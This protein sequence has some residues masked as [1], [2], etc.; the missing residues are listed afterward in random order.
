MSELITTN[1]PVLEEHPKLKEALER[2]ERNLKDGD[3]KNIGN[4][5]RAVL[6]YIFRQYS[7]DDPFVED[8]SLFTMV[9]S[10]GARGYFSPE[11]ISIIEQIRKRGN[12]GS[13]AD[14]PFNRVNP[15]TVE[16][17]RID[18][19]TLVNSF[20][21]QFLENFPKPVERKN[22]V[23]PIFHAKENLKP[24]RNL[25]VS[26]GSYYQSSSLRTDL[27]L[28]DDTHILNLRNA[29]KWYEEE[30]IVFQNGKS[31]NVR[32]GRF[33]IPEE[34]R[35]IFGFS[36][37]SKEKY[38]D[39][40]HKTAYRLVGEYSFSVI[41]TLRAL[42]QYTGNTHTVYAPGV[43]LEQLENAAESSAEEPG[44]RDLINDVEVEALSD[45]HLLILPDDDSFDLA[46][47]G[48]DSWLIRQS[49]I[50]QG[51]RVIGGNTF[52]QLLRFFEIHNGYRVPTCGDPY[53]SNI[54]FEA[55][56]FKERD[57]VTKALPSDY[58]KQDFGKT[59]GYDL[60]F[61]RLSEDVIR[62]L[63]EHPG[64]FISMS[65]EQTATSV[66]EQRIP[67]WISEEAEQLN[68]KGE[69][70]F[71]L[72]SKI[73]YVYQ[74]LSSTEFLGDKKLYHQH[75]LITPIR[76]SL[77]QQNESL[78][79]KPFFPTWMINEKLD[80]TEMHD[81][82]YGKR[83]LEDTTEYNR[84]QFQLMNALKSI[85][86][87]PTYT[88][89]GNIKSIDSPELC[90]RWHLSSEELEW[91]YASM[92]S[93]ELRRLVELEASKDGADAPLYEAGDEVVWNTNPRDKNGKQRGRIDQVRYSKEKGVLYDI[94][95][96][97]QDLSDSR[98]L[99]EGVPQSE[100]TRRYFKNSW[101][102]WDSD[103]ERRANELEFYD[104]IVFTPTEHITSN[105]QDQYIAPWGRYYEVFGLSSEYTFS[106]NC[107][108]RKK[109]N[110]DAEDRFFEYLRTIHPDGINPSR[111][112]SNGNLIG[113]PNT[114]YLPELMDAPAEF[115]DKPF[116]LELILSMRYPEQ[117]LKDSLQVAIDMGFTDDPYPMYVPGDVVLYGNP[118]YKSSG[119]I[120]RVYP[121][122]NGMAKKSYVY[123][124]FEEASASYKCLLTSQIFGLAEAG[125]LHEQY[126]EEAI[127]K[128]TTSGSA[129][130][131][132][133]TSVPEENNAQQ[134]S[135][136][137]PQ[138]GLFGFLKSKLGSSS[139]TS[140]ATRFCS[141][142]GSK[143][144]PGARFCINC[145]KKL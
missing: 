106:S 103:A 131:M 92:H 15:P 117:I 87:E 122:K 1:L 41:D 137:K 49:I 138:G 43:T 93:E 22:K 60:K 142:C 109:K 33:V 129:A 51:C 80:E 17:L 56:P 9:Q 4:S 95:L 78:I 136:D 46:L 73:Q 65:H 127:L 107:Y 29:V 54:S 69:D 143:L 134:P 70:L 50:S 119:E 124:I 89:S 91:Y 45:I 116:A 140:S 59:F 13:H 18:Y 128:Q 133:A 121:Y 12:A 100:I 125:P 11:Q 31:S 74:S 83:A 36:S 40:Y 126:A 98:I 102:H 3:V 34:L 68:V 130:S 5:I 23:H 14:D 61:V 81:L 144:K 76:M 79:W 30:I 58:E 97:Q 101:R 105:G 42:S 26:L 139:G 55:N 104:S 94:F 72:L 21:P 63:D 67:D 113:D 120:I 110:H 6:E 115:L 32:G 90:E 16:E 25:Y 10:C 37:L 64:E 52:D 20:V 66:D 71:D 53:G 123:Y 39:Q 111:F 35:S 7:N 112:D 88:D 44:Q 96:L 85:P 28:N 84:I 57:V 77:Q 114:R 141:A 135:S 108:Y 48:N 27:F 82:S 8:S 75:S 118:K 86:F 38:T 19:E 132:E 99:Y 24:L 62:I 47:P 145:G 2:V